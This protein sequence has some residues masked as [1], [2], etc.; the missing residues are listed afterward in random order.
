MRN[1][2]D[3][4]MPTTEG[5][6]L[7]SGGID[8]NI[9]N[10]NHNIHEHYN[11]EYAHMETWLD[12]HPDFVQDYFLRKATRQVVD[13][14]LVS[15]STPTS[16]T[17]LELASP[18]SHHHH[19]QYGIGNSSS[20]RSCCS[21]G[22][23]GGSSSSGATTPVRKI[24]AHEFEK[25]GLLKPMISTTSDGTPTFLTGSS[26]MIADGQNAEN[27]VGGNNCAHCQNSPTLGQRRQRRSRHELSQMDEKELIF[28]LVSA[29][30]LIN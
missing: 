4:R 18:T 6:V 20:S 21:A 28:E 15:H 27:S 16:T 12:E 30:K 22:G 23:G 5:A 3:Y 14:W 11:Q 7:N 19:Q 29:I 9:N 10:N 24:S 8:G 1:N 26:L 2:E 17:N 13:S 25:G